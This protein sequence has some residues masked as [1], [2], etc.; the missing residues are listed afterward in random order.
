MRSKGYYY[1]FPILLVIILV[2]G[3][4]FSSAGSVYADSPKVVP[5]PQTKSNDPNKY[6]CA[7]CKSYDSGIRK[8]DKY[9]PMSP[10]WISNGGKLHFKYMYYVYNGNEIFPFTYILQKK[11]GNQWKEVKREKK[12]ATGV[13]TW[14]VRILSIND[15][16]L[17]RGKRYRLLF[18][19]DPPNQLGNSSK[20]KNVLHYRIRQK[21]PLIDATIHQTTKQYDMKPVVAFNEQIDRENNKKSRK[22][23]KDYRQI[24][25]V[26]HSTNQNTAG[27]ANKNGLVPYSGAFDY[28]W[29]LPG[30]KFSYFRSL[31]KSK[32]KSFILKHM[33]IPPPS[34]YKGPV[35]PRITG[36]H[37]FGHIGNLNSKKQEKL[38]SKIHMTSQKG[39]LKIK[40]KP[41]KNGISVTA[42]SPFKG[43]KGKWKFKLA[44]KKNPDKPFYSS[45]FLNGD[46]GV[47]KYHF[48]QSHIKNINDLIIQVSF[49]AGIVTNSVNST[50]PD[51]I[52]FYTAKS[53]MTFKN[54]SANHS[55]S[56]ETSQPS[57]QPPKYYP[58]QSKPEQPPLQ[59]KETKQPQKQTE[60]KQQKSKPQNT[61]SHSVD[62]QGKSSFTSTGDL[63]I[64][65]SLKGISQAKGKWKL[66]LADQ[67]LENKS[68]NQ[69]MEFT[70]PKEQLK[71]DKIPVTVQFNG[72]ANG[73]KISGEWKKEV[74]K[75]QPKQQEQKVEI[76][77]QYKV[78]A[79]GNVLLTLWLKGLKKAQGEWK[80]TLGNKEPVVEPAGSERLEYTIPKEQLQDGKT[81]ITVRFNGTSDGKPI[82]GEITLEMIISNLQNEEP[83]ANDDPPTPPSSDQLL[84]SDD[85]AN[86]YIQEDDVDWTTTPSNDSPTSTKS[87]SH[88]IGGPLPKTASSLPSALL[89]GVAVLAIGASLLYLSL[90][91]KRSA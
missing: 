73:K 8:Y 51:K 76:A 53:Q 31:G 52:A 17:E 85:S 90:R 66:L 81:P 37:F 14:K 87:S 68:G 62:I 75:E 59:E 57:P 48:K 71:T 89:T 30:N 6:D 49:D 3:P 2:L 33:P 55:P 67:Q 84:S 65:A 23:K 43:K 47:G 86:N 54:E 28:Y 29:P 35:V 25:V 16:D 5:P 27:F 46:G 12:R 82:A 74:Q 79:N 10:E 19:L 72:S 77:H 1:L 45:R 41:D 40:A 50:Q 60:H 20:A 38:V 78:Q 24:K 34:D 42:T 58:S 70:I 88:V 26:I 18:H 7:Y 22:N 32:N 36:V 9:H 4:C 91:R 61:R 69:Q 15:T 39:K 64:K 56:K 21:D 11:E 83:T 63:M 44:S 80:I 13:N